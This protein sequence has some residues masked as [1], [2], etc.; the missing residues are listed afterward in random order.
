MAIDLNYE[1]PHCQTVTPVSTA[2]V[3]EM[4]ECPKCHQQFRAK[5]PIGHPV[6]SSDHQIKAKQKVELEFDADETLRSVN[7]VYLRNPLVQTSLFSL[8]TLTGLFGI[9]LGLTG[10]VFLGQQGGLTISG[11]MLLVCAAIY[12]FYRWLQVISTWLIVTTHRTSVERGIISMSTNEVQHDDV[13]NIK[14][15]R[16]LLERL[17]NYGDIALSSSGQDDME[18]V[19]HDVPDPDGIIEIIR[20]HQ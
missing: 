19:V 6:A 11:I 10:R 20:Q 9:I 4:V 12:F 2:I 18:I 5:A 16:N 1:C 8:V 3:D 14:S 15:E 13:R 7:P 17:F